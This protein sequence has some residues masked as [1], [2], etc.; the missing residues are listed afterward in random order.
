LDDDKKKLVM[1]GLIYEARKKKRFGFGEE[2]PRPKA[3]PRE[4]HQSVATRRTRV[5]A[6]SDG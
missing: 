5:F 4:R 6:S 3:S 1:Y 2:T